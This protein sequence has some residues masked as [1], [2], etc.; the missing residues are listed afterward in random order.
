MKQARKKYHLTLLIIEMASVE[1]NRGYLTSSF[2]ILSKTSSSSSPGKGDWRWGRNSDKNNFQKLNF[3]RYI[4]LINILK[5]NQMRSEK[6]EGFNRNLHPTALFKF[7]CSSQMNKGNSFTFC[8]A[9]LTNQHFID[10]HTKTPP[11]YSSCIGSFCQ[12]FWSKKFWSAT[13]CTCPVTKTHS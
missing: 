7:I 9:Y 2:T 3:H 10:E 13:E 6:S 11:V 12:H 4:L 8:E 1:R 5:F